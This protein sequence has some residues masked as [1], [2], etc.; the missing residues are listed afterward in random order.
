MITATEGRQERKEGRKL[1][2]SYALGGLGWGTPSPDEVLRPEEEKE[3]PEAALSCFSFSA[4]ALCDQG[5]NLHTGM[6]SGFGD[7]LET[8]F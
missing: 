3:S 4:F 8:L 1:A 6:V 7:S 2:S 5:R